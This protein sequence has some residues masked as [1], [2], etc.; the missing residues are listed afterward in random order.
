MFFMVLVYNL[1]NIIKIYK[2]FKVKNACIVTILGFQCNGKNI[3][4]GE[5][6]GFIQDSSPPHRDPSCAVTY[7]I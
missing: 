5:T 7:T 2:F 6:S 3:K 1:P 4:T